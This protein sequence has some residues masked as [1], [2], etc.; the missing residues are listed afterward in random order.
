M[1]MQVTEYGLVKNTDGSMC[2]TI[3]PDDT[4]FAGVM[5]FALEEST[6]NA[7]SNVLFENGTTGWS[8]GGFQD[9]T[10]LTVLEKQG[11]YNLNAMKVE[12]IDGSSSG[13][14]ATLSQAKGN[15]ANPFTLTQGEKMT[16]SWYVKG[17]GNTIGK[18][19][20][21]HCYASDGTSMIST[22]TVSGNFLRGS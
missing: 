7:F 8:T 2:F 13:T 6:M 14:G 3:R 15:W 12:R 20:R 17:I 1:A 9:N 5:S 10:Q 18:S 16:V 4:P 21:A 22:G 11:L 19:V